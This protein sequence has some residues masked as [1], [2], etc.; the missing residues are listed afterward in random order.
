M[1]E[2]E[3]KSLVWDIRKS[4]LTLSAEGLF[5]IAKE[6]GPVSGLDWSELQKGDH[7]GCFDYISSFMYSKHLLESEDSGMV[8]LLIL[9]D[10]VDAVVSNRDVTDLPDL[11]PHNIQTT[12]Q[13]V[14]TAHTTD[15]TTN[16]M[17]QAVG[18]ASSTVPLSSVLPSSEVFT[19]S[20]VRSR[21]A[22]AVA[23][24]TNTELLKMLTSYEELGKKLRQSMIVPETQSL[25]HTPLLP[26]QATKSHSGSSYNNFTD[27]PAREGMISLRDLSYLQRREFKVQGGQVGDQSSDISYNNVCKQVEEGIK[28]GFHD[29]EIVRGVLRIIKPGTFKDMLINKDDLTVT[30]LKGFLQAHLREKNSTELFQELM[31]A[32]QDENETPQQFL[33]R[34]IGLKQRVLFTSKLSD[35]GIKYSA[36][37]VQDVFLHTVY[38]G[39]GYKHSD[40]RRE[41]KPLL[42]S[43]EV[44]DET[45][46]RQVMRITSE[47][48]ERQKRIG[49]SR[50]QTTTSAHSAQF[51]PNTFQERSDKQESSTF[52]TKTD[53]IKELAAK[54]DELTSLIEAMRQQRQPRPAD[55]VNQYSQNKVRM[56]REKP[57]GCPKCVEQ[58][59]LDCS[60]C[61]YCGEGGHRAVGCLQKQKSQGNANRSLQWGAQ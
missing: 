25:E 56:K 33:Y 8:D 22:S 3:R 20:P 19:T 5:H 49:S 32:R 13:T 35:A 15:D 28:E 59:R 43:G 47:E 57:Y 48:S 37:T 29:T 21:L 1:S 41:L 46:L 16:L 23:D 60:H 30:E 34:V 18:T 31:C 24:T 26:A 4:L 42:S 7:E 40:V 11:E 54:V 36:A 2:S 44:S 9:K 45:I 58:N 61:F 17:S 27:Q 50:R 51:E 38:Q 10:A 53:P 55:P 6:V 39:L 52:K 12:T 14:H